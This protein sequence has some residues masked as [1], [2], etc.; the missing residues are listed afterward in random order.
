M[1]CKGAIILR[2]LYYAAINNGAFST[3]NNTKRHQ[4]KFSWLQIKKDFNFVI[5]QIAKIWDP[6]FYLALEP[7]VLKLEGSS[8]G[9]SPS[10]YVLKGWYDD[11]P[12]KSSQNSHF[13][14]EDVP[15]PSPA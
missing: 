1:V 11:Y 10:I 3:K 2:M 13:V 6:K 12:Q 5:Q 7:K 8:F 14:A 15:P 4:F 9:N